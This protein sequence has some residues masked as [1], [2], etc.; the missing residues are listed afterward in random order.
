[1][2]WLERNHY[3]FDEAWEHVDFQL[4]AVYDVV[5]APD[6]EISVLSQP[7]G[8]L[9][10]VREGRCRITLGR[11]RVVAEA[12]DAVILTAGE[13]RVTTNIGGSPLSIVGFSCRA[14]LLELVDFLALLDLPLRWPQAA[15]RLGELLNGI[16]EERR[17]GRFAY[18][19]A[20]HGLA[21]MALVE[22]LR[23]V[24]TRT[25]NNTIAKRR[26]GERLRAV[27]SSDI[28]AALTFVAGHFEEPLDVPALAAAACLSPK[29]FSRKFKTALHLTP[30][31]YLRNYRLRHAQDM[32]TSSDAT[33]SQIAWKCGF[34]DPAHFSRAFKQQYGV[35]PLIF[36]HSFR[37]LVAKD[38]HSHP[39]SSRK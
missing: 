5:A 22:V 37:S 12:G 18:P 7:N 4:I 36:R 27:Q 31:E 25:S 34:A 26:L 3:S 39:S 32:L 30:M 13:R 17:A 19:L 14:T 1:M 16:V 8:E 15:P 33:V 9:W 11:R 24:E 28:A 35:S 20:A 2:T 6:W 38:E 29:H 23:A 10:L 21:Q